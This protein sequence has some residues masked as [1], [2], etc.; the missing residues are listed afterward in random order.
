ML[1]SYPTHS[2]LGNLYSWCCWVS[3]TIPCIFKALFES[4]SQQAQTRPSYVAST[5]IRQHRILET[6][7][8]CGYTANSSSIFFNEFYF[9]SLQAMTCRKGPQ[10]IKTACQNRQ[11]KKI[12]ITDHTRKIGLASGCLRSPKET[13]QS[14]GPGLAFKITI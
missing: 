1:P 14:T 3:T 2:D 4:T 9:C 12:R 13:R 10:T 6:K 8:R 5:E 7:A 11:I